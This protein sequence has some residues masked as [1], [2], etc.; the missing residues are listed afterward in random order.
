MAGRDTYGQ[1]EMINQEDVASSR[2]RAQHSPN[3]MA[4]LPRSSNSR[5]T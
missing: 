4:E 3:T 1:C 2:Q 5:M